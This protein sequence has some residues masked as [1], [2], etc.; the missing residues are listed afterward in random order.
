MT[1]LMHFYVLSLFVLIMAAS[2]SNNDDDVDPL[3][4]G[5]NFNFAN[6]VQNELND[7]IAAANAFGLDQSTSNCTALKNAYQNYINALRNIDSCIPTTDRAA[8]L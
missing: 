7:V 3:F 4:C 8:Y 6:E 5:T 2:C 1:R